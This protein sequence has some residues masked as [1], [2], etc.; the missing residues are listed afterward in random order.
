MQGKRALFRRTIGA[1]PQGTRHAGMAG[2]KRDYNH[3]VARDQSTSNNIYK[4][5]I[6][7]CNPHPHQ[8][9]QSINTCIA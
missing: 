4:C 8:I 7:V 3:L 2:G 6:P 5:V 1:A 9:N